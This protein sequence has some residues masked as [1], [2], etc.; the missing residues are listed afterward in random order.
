MLALVKHHCQFLTNI[1]QQYNWF[2]DDVKQRANDDILQ[3]FEIFEQI[4][5][6][7]RD[8]QILHE[9]WED[10]FPSIWTNM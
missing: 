7:Y 6:G 10:L 8:L 1:Q 4:R 3:G 2:Q 9:F 5:L